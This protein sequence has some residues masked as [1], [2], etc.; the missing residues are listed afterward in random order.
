MAF[1]KIQG[2]RGLHLE[3]FEGPGDFQVPEEAGTE[4]PRALG[5][6]LGMASR[7]AEG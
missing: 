2:D 7:C 6:A 5:M 4:G 3:S 1:N